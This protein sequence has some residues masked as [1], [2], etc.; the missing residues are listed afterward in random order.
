MVPL[1]LCFLSGRFAGEGELEEGG[2]ECGREE[3]TF[4]EDF[5]GL[6]RVEEEEEEEE[7]G[8]GATEVLVYTGLGLRTDDR[9]EDDDVSVKEEVMEEEEEEVVVVEGVR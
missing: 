2:T 9:R 1:L 3:R 7:E 6:W 4:V 8:A 5:P